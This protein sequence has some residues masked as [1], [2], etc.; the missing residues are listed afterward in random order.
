MSAPLVIRR[1]SRTVI[2]HGPQGSGKTLHAVR[3]ARAFKLDNVVDEWDH[4]TKV[5]CFDHLIL[6]V[7]LPAVIPDGVVVLSLAEALNAAAIAE[8]GA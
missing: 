3:L 7:D 1:M 5:P 4:T 8:A 6:T 2:V